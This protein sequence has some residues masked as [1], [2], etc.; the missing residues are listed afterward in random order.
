MYD[1]HPSMTSQ[2]AN[3][4]NRTNQVA[5]NLDLLQDHL[6]DVASLVGISDPDIFMN[7]HGTDEDRETLLSLMGHASPP[8]G[9]SNA[10]TPDF[11]VTYSS[12][13]QTE[14]EDLLGH[15]EDGSN[16]PPLDED[17]FNQE[18]LDLDAIKSGRNTQ[19]D[20]NLDALFNEKAGK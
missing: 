9:L 16:M 14:F 2:I 12:N 10:P 17:D 4:E 18:L 13:E 11:P 7:F 1:P 19:Y 6:T 5:E 3:M 15:L 8:G 20:D